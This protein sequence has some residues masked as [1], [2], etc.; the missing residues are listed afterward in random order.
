MTV[1]AWTREETEALSRISRDVTRPLYIMDNGNQDIIVREIRAAVDAER[2]V[3]AAA[4]VK[5][6]TEYGNGGA[7]PSDVRAISAALARGQSVTDRG[8]QR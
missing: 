2:K 4:L 3:I 7:F 6:E 1:S 8:D 5:A